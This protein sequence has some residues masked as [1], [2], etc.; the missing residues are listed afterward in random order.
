MQ[1]PTMTKLTQENPFYEEVRT[2]I[3]KK[4]RNVLIVI[5]GGTGTGKSYVAI[6]IAKD[7][8]PTFTEKTMKDRIISEPKDFLTIM[9]NPDL[10]KGK[11][12]IFDEAGVGVPAREWYSINNRAID[13]ILQTFRYRNLIVIFTVPLLSYVD[14]HA[15]K[16]FRF[17][18]ETVDVDFNERTNEVKVFEFSINPKTGKIYMKYPVLKFRGYWRKF[19]RWRFGIAPAKIVHEYEKIA[20]GI[21]ERVQE[22]ERRKLA[23]VEEKEREKEQDQHV[24]AD[25]IAKEIIANPEPFITMFRGQQVISG[26]RIFARFKT[27]SFLAQRI[28]YIVEDKLR[29]D[30]IL[31]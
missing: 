10:S 4:N 20:R 6:K 1:L 22:R 2:L 26:N 18:M 7:L 9:D 5:T 8:D 17:Y 29:A 31:T 19:T 14:T 3:Y 13:Y 30:G 28:K 21:K 15:R 27:S 16:L 25:A 11:V 24:D 12:L 23:S